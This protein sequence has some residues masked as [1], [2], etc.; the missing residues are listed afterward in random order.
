MLVR[1]IYLLASSEDSY[2]SI[3][4]NIRRFLP[5]TY[6]R[7]PLVAKELTETESNNKNADPMVLNENKRLSVFSTS[8]NEFKV[9]EFLE[10]QMK[11]ADIRGVNVDAVV[12]PE[13]EPKQSCCVLSEGIKFTFNND[14][15][16]DKVRNKVATKGIT[17]TLC[18]GNFVKALIHVRNPPRNKQRTA[19]ALDMSRSVGAIFARLKSALFQKK[20]IRSV[21]MPLLGLGTF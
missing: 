6:L 19:F 9:T 16:L 10:I 1:D 18:T 21:A 3:L 14:I 4:K 5:D 8:V 20:E 17:K 11:T 12:C 7:L 2:V 13:N 15:D